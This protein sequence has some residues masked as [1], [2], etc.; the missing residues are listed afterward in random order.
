MAPGTHLYICGP[1]GFMAWCLEAA[2]R[3]G[4]P[5]AQV[6][7]EYFEA[8]EPADTKTEIEF[9]IKLAS[10]GA[11]LKVPQ[12]VSILSVLR[13]HGI[14]VP[15]S[16][17]TGVCGTCLTQVLAG[18]PDHRDVYLSKQERAAGDVILPCC[19]RALSPLLIL[20]I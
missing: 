5:D 14:A 7:V 17:E 8:A 11:T 13:D 6:H 1:A 18:E 9:D 2:A 19:S 15:A 3:A 10:S 12:N 4:V 16:C 20:D